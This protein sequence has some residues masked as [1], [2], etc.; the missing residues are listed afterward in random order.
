MKKG[1]M[2]YAGPKKVKRT[3][4][5]MLFLQWFSKGESNKADRKVG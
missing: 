5:Q 2:R 4:C 1:V 3:S